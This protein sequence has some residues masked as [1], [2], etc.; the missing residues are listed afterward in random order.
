METIQ[1]NKYKVSNSN[2]NKSYD[3]DKINNK[4]FL[5]DKATE[6]FI[7]NI[8]VNENENPIVTD[9]IKTIYRFKELQYN[10]DTYGAEKISVESISI[11]IQIVKIF[12]S[13]NLLVNYAFPMRNGGVLLEMNFENYNL[14]LEINENNKI[15]LLVFNKDNDFKF[16][17]DYDIIDLANLINKLK[18]YYGH[19]QH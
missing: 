1:K 6:Y 12:E 3:F 18:E 9:L 15:N 8:L 7:K 11:A 16:E 4:R 19:L 2:L 10:W 5:T 14:E 17:C 13:S